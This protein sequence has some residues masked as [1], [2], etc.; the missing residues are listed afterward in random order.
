[1]NNLIKNKLFAELDLLREMLP[2][3]I[4]RPT[5][6]LLFLKEL[7]CV[8]NTVIIY[9]ILLTIHVTIASIEMSFSK[10]KLLKT[11]LRSSMS[12]EQDFEMIESVMYNLIYN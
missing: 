5:D 6:I 9:R 12:Q 3:E 4:I 8:Y 7:D 10:L 1:M 11:Y 2:K